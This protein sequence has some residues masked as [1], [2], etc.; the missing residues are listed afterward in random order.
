MAW[1]LF[2]NNRADF[3]DNDFQLLVLNDIVLFNLNLP[4][5]VHEHVS[6]E[7]VP[8]VKV[9]CAAK[10]NYRDFKLIGQT[11]DI[12]VALFSKSSAVGEYHIQLNEYLGDSSFH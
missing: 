8:G 1:N 12:F 9:P 5:F 2:G 4:V 11:Y 3:Q 7:E 6:R 10:S